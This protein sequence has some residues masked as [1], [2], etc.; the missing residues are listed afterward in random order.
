MESPETAL[1]LNSDSMEFDKDIN[2]CLL[3]SDLYS[4]EGKGK[5]YIDKQ[6]QVSMSSHNTS[7]HS[8]F[9]LVLTQKHH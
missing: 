4:R 9:T 1:N 3:Y 2:H 7:F 8:P 5:V 6:T